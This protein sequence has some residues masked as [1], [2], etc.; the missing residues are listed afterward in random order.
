MEAFP[1]DGTAAVAALDGAIEI[2]PLVD[3]ADRGIGG[4]G[5]IE[6]GD[7]FA[8][9]DLSQESEGAVEH[10]GS[11][12]R[13]DDDVAVAVPVG[14]LQPER[15][16][17]EIGV[18]AGLRKGAAHGVEGSQ[19]DGGFGWRA[20]FLAQGS[21]DHAADSTEDFLAGGGDRCGIA[22]GGDH[23]RDGLAILL[24]GWSGRW[25][26]AEPGVAAGFGVEGEG[27]Q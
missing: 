3:P 6:G 19:H 14:G 9:G 4:L 20:G 10:A 16:G 22:E 25:G 13:G 2:V 18:E 8:E 26:V 12:S 5:F 15:V 7:G 17:L 23:G 1:E 21:A 27:S 11:V 24:E